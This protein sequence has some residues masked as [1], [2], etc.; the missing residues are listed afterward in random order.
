LDINDDINANLPELLAHKMWKIPAIELWKLSLKAYD[1]H[2][3]WL[4]NMAKTPE[5][6]PIYNWLINTLRL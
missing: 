4:D 6:S 2:T 5:F 3:R 1:S